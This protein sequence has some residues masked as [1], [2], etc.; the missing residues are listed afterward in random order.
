M[1]EKNAFYTCIRILYV[2]CKGNIYLI[3]IREHP[4]N[5]KGEGGGGLWVFSESK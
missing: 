4:F 3:C 5:L 2:N 1:T